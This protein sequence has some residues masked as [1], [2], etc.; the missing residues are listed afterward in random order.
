MKYYKLGDLLNLECSRGLYGCSQTK[1]PHEIYELSEILNEDG[2][3]CQT[4]R[5]QCTVCSYERIK[6]VWFNLYGS[7]DLLD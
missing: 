4:L 6:P 5:V 2:T 1:V 7:K 3:T